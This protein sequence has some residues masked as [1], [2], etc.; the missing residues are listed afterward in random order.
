MCSGDFLYS[1]D[2]K[3]KSLLRVEAGMSYFKAPDLLLGFSE[4]IFRKLRTI[5]EFSSESPV[6]VGSSIIF[7]W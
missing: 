5:S 7:L 6:E 4:T 3:A 1:M 2:L